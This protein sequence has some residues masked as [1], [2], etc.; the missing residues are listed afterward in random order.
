MYVE[1]K[2]DKKSQDNFLWKLMEVVVDDHVLLNSKISDKTVRIKQCSIVAKIDTFTSGTKIYPSINGN[3]V[4]KKQS[5]INDKRIDC[6]INF[7]TREYPLTKRTYSF[8]IRRDKF[9]TKK[10]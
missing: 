7:V 5:Q 1:K 6:L 8:L 9:Q 4:N 10:V 3:L 2:T